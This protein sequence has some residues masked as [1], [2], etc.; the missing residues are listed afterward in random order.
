M[1]GTLIMLRINVMLAF[2]KDAN[3]VSEVWPDWN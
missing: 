1:T 3:E 2:S